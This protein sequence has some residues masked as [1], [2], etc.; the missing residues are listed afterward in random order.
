MNVDLFFL[1]WKKFPKAWQ[2]VGFSSNI[3]T[4]SL[5]MKLK[6]VTESWL[7]DTLKLGENEVMGINHKQ[8]GGEMETLIG[9][10]G[11]WLG[12]RR[13][14]GGRVMIEEHL[15][16][17]TKETGF[18]SVGEEVGRYDAVFFS[19]FSPPLVT[20]QCILCSSLCFCPSASH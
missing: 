17:S 20:L 16:S 18:W 12:D 14:T 19:V 2:K 3:L 15:Y 4:N 13:K 1:P 10:E 6:Q 8:T 9:Y 5:V 7:Q 11:E